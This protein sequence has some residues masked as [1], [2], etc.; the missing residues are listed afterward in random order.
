MPIWR[1]HMARR[2][3]RRSQTRARDGMSALELISLTNQLLFV[4]LF[5]A[6]IV[7]AV[8]RPSRA[9]LDTVVLFGSIAIAV[10]LARLAGWFGF[11]GPWVTGAVLA[12]VS[13]APWA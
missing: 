3:L 12:L 5:V 2:V 6:A 1:R 4:G 9:A 8:R 7:H 10:L 13:V 11:G